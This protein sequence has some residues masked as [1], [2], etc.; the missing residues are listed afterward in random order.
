VT[1]LV[2]VTVCYTVGFTPHGFESHPSLSYMLHIPNIHRK[3]LQRG[4]SPKGQ[5]IITKLVKGNF[6]LRA[7]DSAWLSLQHLEIIRLT[8]AR[9]LK[10]KKGSIYWIRLT[11]YHSWSKKPSATR[12]GKG[13]GLPHIWTAWAKPGTI[14]AEWNSKNAVAKGIYNSL[15]FKLPIPIDLIHEKSTS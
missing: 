6:G 11:P 8:I 1:E 9:R 3:K 4:S 12:I 10:R 14:I 15:R 5:P 7:L 13:K 2:K